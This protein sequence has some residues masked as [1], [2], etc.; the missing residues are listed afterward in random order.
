MGINKS[1][2]LKY[3]HEEHGK[4][5]KSGKNELYEGTYKGEKCIY[6]YTSNYNVENE[7]LE[8]LRQKGDNNPK[9]YYYDKGNY[10]SPNGKLF[11]SLIIEKMN[12]TD[13]FEEVAL[14]RF[15][16]CHN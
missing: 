6:K 11:S 2:P 10:I 9:L 13:L 7:V 16:K 12:G 15:L 8:L 5:V 3:H 1:V 14:F 4:W